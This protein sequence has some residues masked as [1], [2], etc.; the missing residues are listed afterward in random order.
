LKSFVNN[1]CNFSVCAFGEEDTHTHTHIFA[2]LSYK[3]GAEHT[4]SDIFLYSA[5]YGENHSKLATIFA[6][7]FSQL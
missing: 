1:I 6:I 5:I 2:S 3:N 4:F 7:L